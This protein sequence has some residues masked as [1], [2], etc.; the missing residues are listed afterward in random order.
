MIIAY[1]ANKALYNKLPTAINSLLSN[2]K[3][4][5]IYLFIEDDN[6][7]YISHPNIEFVNC[8]KVDIPVR[9]GM[10]VSERFPY[11]ALV[12]L[13]L[14]NL[15]KEDKVVYLD[16]DTVVDDSL[17]DLWGIDLGSDLIGAVEE[18]N[19]YCN[20]GVILFNLKG[21]RKANL[22]KNIKILLSKC[23]MQF[24]DQDAMNQ[25]FQDRILLLP[26][27]YNVLGRAMYVYGKTEIAIRHYAGQKKPWLDDANEQDNA[28]WNKYFTT[29][30]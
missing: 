5:K 3:V 19:K 26:K 12:R 27:K 22:D 16:V 11:L 1:C 23:K 9:D 21:I 25:V 13:F 28:F 17:E 7:D 29:K 30:I 20:S 2:N 6:I 10:N 24:P 4:E 14:H 8:E 15:L 18:T